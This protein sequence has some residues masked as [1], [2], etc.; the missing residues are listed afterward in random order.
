MIGGGIVC[1]IGPPTALFQTA[2]EYSF[3]EIHIN[4]KFDIK[5]TYMNIIQLR[6]LF[7]LELKAKSIKQK[8]SLLK[9]IGPI[10]YIF[11]MKKTIK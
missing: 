6:N 9:I 3:Y 11:N 7:I 4:C 2:M 1:K 10:T 8:V 5:S